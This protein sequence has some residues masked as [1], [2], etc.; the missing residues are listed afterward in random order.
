M[1][2]VERRAVQASAR[3]G[4]AGGGH[5][6]R[7]TVRK[8]AGSMLILLLLPRTEDCTGA[9]GPSDSAHFPAAHRRG[10]ASFGYLQ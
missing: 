6:A 7:H 3:A 10:P 8:R 9:Q 2:T 1:P 4:G 5:M